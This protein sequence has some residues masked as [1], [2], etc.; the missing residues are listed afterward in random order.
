MFLF[1]KTLDF[2]VGMWYGYFVGIT[3]QM[4]R[5]RGLRLTQ[6]WIDK[7]YLKLKTYI[8]SK[9]YLMCG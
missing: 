5:L 7:A 3:A 8:V 2:L 9:P 1:V 4:L 6:K